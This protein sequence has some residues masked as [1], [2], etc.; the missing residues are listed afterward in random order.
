[1]SVSRTPLY[2]GGLY[3]PSQIA[4][5]LAADLNVFDRNL[6]GNVAPEAA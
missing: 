3:Q 4:D 2:G 5:T 6:G 1:M